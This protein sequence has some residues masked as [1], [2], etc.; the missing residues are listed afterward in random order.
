MVALDATTGKQIWK[1]YTIPE[2]P[3]KTTKN[4]IG[5]QLWGPS[6]A[7]IWS[8]PSIDAKRNALYATTGDNYSDPTSEHE[9]RVRGLRSGYAAKFYG[10]GR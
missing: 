1:T 2:E 4:K 5:T 9:R 6:G 3:H 10:R 8:S 7:P